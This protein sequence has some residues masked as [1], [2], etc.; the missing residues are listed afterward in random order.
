MFFC[1]I[2]GPQT[3]ES[4]REFLHGVYMNFNCLQAFPFGLGAKK[5]RG[6][7]FS[8]MAVF[9]NRLETLATQ[10]KENVASVTSIARVW[11]VYSDVGRYTHCLKR[12]T[13]RNILFFFPARFV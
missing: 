3:L 7:G 11:F 5:D 10:A 13:C 9:L 12:L 2:K 4:I 6:T 8:V 1:P